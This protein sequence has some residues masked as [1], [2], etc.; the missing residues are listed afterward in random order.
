MNRADSL[1]E[2]RQPIDRYLDGH[3]QSLVSFTAAVE[4]EEHDM[5]PL[6]LVHFLYVIVVPL[7]VLLSVETWLVNLV[8]VQ[9]RQDVW[10]GDYSETALCLIQ[11]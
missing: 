10:I 4:L 6:V 1:P 5:I 8:E 9:L 11:T 7:Y 2:G 3:D